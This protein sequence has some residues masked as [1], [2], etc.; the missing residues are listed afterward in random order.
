MYEYY[1][2]TGIKPGDAIAADSKGEKSSKQAALDFERM[3]EYYVVAGVKPSEAPAPSTNSK[4]KKNPSTIPKRK[5]NIYTSSKGNEKSKQAPVAVA[6][7]DEF[8][9]LEY[10]D[11]G[12]YV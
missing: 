9:Q 12:D 4:G 1:K 6:S 5:K 10:S 11:A 7:E 3:N 2:A 8:D